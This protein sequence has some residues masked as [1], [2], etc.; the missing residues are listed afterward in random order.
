MQSE[1][2]HH[3]PEPR[4]EGL[5]EVLTK[6]SPAI[7]AQLSWVIMQFIDTAMVGHLGT[8]QLAA[9]GSAGLWSWVVVSFFIGLLSCVST[10]VSQ[11]VGRGQAHDCARYAWQGVY[12][13]L[14]TAVIGFALLPLS[15]PF[16]ESMG[17][18]RDVTEYELQYFQLRLMGFFLLPWQAVLA[19]FFLGINRPKIP[20][21]VA[22]FA[23][24]IN[25]FLGF[26]L[27]FGKFGF[28]RLEV[29]GAAIAMMI[30]VLIQ[31]VLMQTIFLGKTLRV[32][33]G[34]L[35][36]W[37]FDGHRMA[38]LLRIG[39]GAGTTWLLDVITWG[40]FTSFIVGKSG[41]NALAAHNGA[42]S[43]MQ[44]S[45]Q[46]AIGLN[47]AIAP[48]VGRWIGMG[49]I[50]RAK[51]RTY[52]ATKL[53]MGY[54]FVMGV[55]FAVF[56]KGLLILA[57]NANAEVASFGHY[58]LIM[59]AIFQG[60]DAI[61]IVMSGAL[62]GAGDTKWQAIVMGAAAYFLFL[63]MA[64]VLARFLNWGAFGAWVGATIYI[65]SLSGIFYYRFA[66]EKWRH[67]NI[68]TPRTDP[69]PAE[70]LPAERDLG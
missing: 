34:T 26:G 31:C 36:A 8:A 39:M 55:I 21:A 46:L 61:T 18:E 3:G 40:V 11:C 14:G 12:L 24:L 66:G 7:V 16:F 70:P 67:I 65:I 19:G 44:V 68:F 27:I 57:F 52:T 60:F 64:F 58:L 63:P 5:K 45:F 17:H 42:I 41:A 25:V 33:Y 22:I 6:A 20:M 28:P 54:M 59:A 30:A 47:Q 56:G 13:A 50:D 2:L 1:Q 15:R 9:V 62:R 43:I 49:R 29:R 35:G 37:R 53:A 10:F 69:A 23:N 32:E 51:A 48:I 38:E 4:W